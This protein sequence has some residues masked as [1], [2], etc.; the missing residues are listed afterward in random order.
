MSVSAF[1]S[2]FH[3]AAT[4]YEGPSFRSEG[5]P[6]T[7]PG[8]LQSLHT[9]CTNTNTFHASIISTHLPLIFICTHPTTTREHCLLH[10]STPLEDAFVPDPTST[11]A[12]RE[13]GDHR[14][15]LKPNFRR[16]AGNVRQRPRSLDNCVIGL[17]T[18]LSSSDLGRSKL[19]SL[20][21]DECR[22]R[23]P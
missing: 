18:T 2:Q 22:S 20:V 7:S 6:C 1:H 4:A 11:S 12:P 13:P 14:P 16:A 8:E 21:Q 9:H 23:P 17:P 15:I 19:Q 3:R 5:Y 10:S